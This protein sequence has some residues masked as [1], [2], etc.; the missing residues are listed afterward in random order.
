MSGH[1]PVVVWSRVDGDRAIAVVAFDDDPRPDIQVAL[2]RTAK[3]AWKA[4]G[5]GQAGD[6]SPLVRPL[7]VATRIAPAPD[8]AEAV[9]LRD[10]DGDEVEEPVIAGNVFQAAWDVE[11]HGDWSFPEVVAVRAAG[12]WQAVT[13]S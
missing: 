8:G 3:R 11:Y 7:G 12:G 10:G 2:V 1:R 5:A 6:W 4:V 9:R 13:V